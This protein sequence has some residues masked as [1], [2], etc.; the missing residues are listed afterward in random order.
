MASRGDLFVAIDLGATS[1]RVIVGEVDGERITATECSRFENR[2]VR[3][4]GLM[5][6]DVL[7]LWAD[8]TTGLARAAAEN[9]GIRSVAV[10]T[11]GV[12]VALT[13]GER[14]LGNPVHYR[15]TRTDAVTEQVHG[16]VPPEEWLDI[17]PQM[18]HVHAKFYDIDES[19]EEPAIDYPELVRVFVEG[20]YR[21][22]WSSEWEGHAF[23]ELGEVDPLVL[24]RRQH[25]LIR[26]SA[27]ELGTTV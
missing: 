24:V 8:A 21:G 20:G 9:P 3:A 12:D 2:P 18:F 11:W 7:S 5:Q 27:A 17:M 22:F 1:G 6:W 14:L 10:D 23:A 19:G 13:R 26:A 4:G 25:D 15:D 16:L